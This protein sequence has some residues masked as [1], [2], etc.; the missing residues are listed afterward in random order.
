MKILPVFFSVQHLH[1]IFE[2]RK[3]FCSTVPSQ[4]FRTLRL[5]IHKTC[6]ARC[7]IFGPFKFFALQKFL[8]GPL[9]ALVA[10]KLY[11]WIQ[12]F[13][14]H[15][16]KITCLLACVWNICSVILVSILRHLWSLSQNST[17]N[18]YNGVYITTTELFLYFLPSADTINTA[19][20]DL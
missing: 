17:F 8:N 20:Y 2:T 15:Y 3:V 19:V 6:R 18:I 16:C 9:S 13:S 14:V 7:I 1:L 12:N 11:P 4:N 5:W 10:N